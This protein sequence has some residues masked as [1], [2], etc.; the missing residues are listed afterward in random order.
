M[1]WPVAATLDGK[2][3]VIEKE[4]YLETWAAMEELVHTGLTKHIGIS[5]FAKAELDAVLANA[6]IKPAAHEFE[7]HPYLQQQD[8]VDYH[9]E[10]GIVVIAYSP[11]ANTNPTYGKGHKPIMEDPTIVEMAEAKNCTPAQYILAWGRQRGTV[12]I[13]KSVHEEWIAE[14]LAS[15]QVYLY[16]WEMDGVAKLDKKLRFNNPSKQW[17]VDLFSDLDG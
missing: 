2:K 9:R 13:P 14:N 15:G 1:H 8:F 3:N 4:S 11:L 7:T 16:P 12:V 17:G 10:K 6:T 5:N